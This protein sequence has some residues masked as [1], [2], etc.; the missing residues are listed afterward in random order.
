MARF[1]IQPLKP[2]RIIRWL[3]SC[4]I[5][6]VLS[7]IFFIFAGRA[8]CYVAI[9]QIG[10]LT[11]T[12]IKTESV[13]FRTNGSVYIKNLVIRPEQKQEQE[14]DHDDTIIDAKMVF[15]RF[16]LGSLLRLRPRLKAIDVNDFVV[17]AQYNQDTHQWN[18]SAL[19]L[20]PPKGGPGRMPRVRLRAGTL[21]YSKISEGQAKVA[22]SVPLTATF[23]SNDQTQNGYSFEITTATTASGYGQSR[24]T[25]AWKPGNITIAGGISS[26]D[27]PELEMAW[28]IDILAA[29]LKYDQGNAFSLKLRVK[30]L[31]SKRSPALERLTLIGPAFLERSG[32]FAALQSFFNHYEP[33]GQVDIELEAS[34]N[35][36]RLIE[37]TLSGNVYC[38][39]VAIC[40][41]K[42]QYPVERLA[43][44][45][46]FTENSVTLCNLVGHHG[47]AELFFNGWCRDF[48]PDR[49]YQIQI[50]S[51]HMPLDD[52]LYKAL[53]IKQQAFWNAFSP[54]GLAAVD[55][56]FTR[57]S[58]TNKRE[59][60]DVELLGVGAVYEHFPYPLE[61]LSGH[62]LFEGNQAVFSNVVSK[63]NERQ[64]AVNGRITTH[65]TDKSTYDISVNVN[66]FLL[67]STLEAAL[68][69]RQ[70]TLYARCHPEGLADG[71]VRIMTQD[72]APPSF[73]ADLSF[74][75]ASLKSGEFPLTVAGVTAKAAFMPGLIT[76]KEFSGRHGDGLI[77]LTGQIQP[78][79]QQGQ[80]LYD[81]AVEMEHMPLNEDL[82]SLLPDSLKTTVSEFKPEG[83]VNLTA[84]IS[85]ENPTKHPDY[86]LHLECLGNSMTLP[87][88][89][90]PLEGITGGLTLDANHIELKDV[91]ATLGNQVST[92]D[93]QATIQLDGEMI[94]TDGVFNS[95]FLTLF[96]R[97]I[98]LDEQL[99][100][101]LPRHI[102]PSYDRLSPMGLFDLAFDRI[103][104][105]R[106]PEGQKFIDVAGNVTL[107]N[108]SFSASGSRVRLDGPFQTDGLYKTGEGFV[109]CRAVL[110]RGTLR[111]RG[112]SFTDLEAD[113]S[114][115]PESRSWSTDNLIADCYDGKLSGRFRFQEPAEQAG[116]YMLQTGFVDIDLKQFLS[117]TELEQAAA[118]GHTSGKMSG[119]LC[120]NAVN[121]D[122]AS[123]IGTCKL[124][125]SDMQVGK[126]SPLAKLLQVLRLTEPKDYAFNRMLVDAYI[127]REGLLVRKLDLSGQNIAFSGAGRM[128][129]RESSVDL[130]LTARGRRLATDDPSVLQSLTEG[131]GR[132]VV[133]MSVTGDFHDPKVKTET[134]PVIEGTLQVLGAMPS[135]RN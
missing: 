36:N 55:C 16:S 102:Q 4:A 81:L 110:D 71:W 11:N 6:A 65:G 96:A 114:Y 68:P 135:A 9:Q 119:S 44:R 115:E 82:F 84:Q 99:G 112:K 116:Q 79:L 40:H 7:W 83:R 78:A 127:R 122:G 20:T 100:L 67:D 129:L 123:R 128:D 118:G 38:K 30:D 49:K 77:S 14:Q 12:K 31:R 103:H 126:L 17:N 80:S 109:S 15:A 64:I 87:D 35:L 133:R 106:T 8:L 21:Q 37:S 32:P 105:T 89:P 13:D 90:Y 22:V 23:E 92:I 57:E 132:A 73:V 63:V 88:F 47:D 97:D 61:N 131:L 46:N 107:R 24:L 42:F 58:Q 75:Q 86:V 95:G 48:G 104:F 3:V 94:L 113:I 124:S 59:K 52:D 56:L 101:M 69:E 74:R 10:E 25:G 39:D 54:T 50:T 125:V 62:L 93:S 98:P 1:R 5:L 108:C 34:G 28:I 29:E 19:K 43:G 41:H 26:I 120:I 2:K 121:G 76:I 70:K 45:I 91:T 72:S 60:L 33:R 134:L 85:K 27:V 51:D 66:N 130:L 111:V 18:I 53:S 117:D